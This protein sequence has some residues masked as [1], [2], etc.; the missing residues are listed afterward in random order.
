M[1]LDRIADPASGQAAGRRRPGAGAWWSGSGRAG[2][3]AGGSGRHRR[4]L[5]S[6]S[7]ATAAEKALAALP[8]IETCP[9]SC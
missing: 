3:H 4:W 9:R 8:G 7:C 1:A 5:R 2:L 6:R